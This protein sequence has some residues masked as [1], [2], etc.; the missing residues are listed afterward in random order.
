MCHDYYGGTKMTSPEIVSTAVGGMVLLTGI[1]RIGFI[2]ASHK[3]DPD[4]HPGRYVDWDAHQE[5][6]K[7]ENIIARDT[8]KELA[9]INVHLAE[10]T[11][12]LKAKLP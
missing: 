8:T 2:L 6:I 4:P 11:A 12:T 5:R 3:V 9:A 10:I 7:E 1:V